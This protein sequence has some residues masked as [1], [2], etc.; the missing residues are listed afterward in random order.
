[1]STSAHDDPLKCAFRVTLGKFL[2]FVVQKEGI[3]IDPDKVKSI[4]QM[5][6]LRN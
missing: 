4:I 1:L 3:E 6:S 5:L 2:G